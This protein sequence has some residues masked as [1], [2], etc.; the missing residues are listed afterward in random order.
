[1]FKDKVNTKYFERMT[2]NLI[3]VFPL[4]YNDYYLHY[5]L[6]KSKYK[7]CSCMR[8][9]KKKKLI[10]TPLFEFGSQLNIYF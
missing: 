10:A 1:M 8:S 6:K 3:L 2:L 5:F 4:Y 7:Y 9:K